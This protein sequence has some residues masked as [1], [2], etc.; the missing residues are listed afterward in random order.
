MGA[1]VVG[2]VGRGVGSDVVDAGKGG[3]GGGWIRRERGRRSRVLLSF[4]WGFGFE[5]RLGW[6]SKDSIRCSQS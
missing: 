1:I 5:L 6:V 4:G 2:G 3:D